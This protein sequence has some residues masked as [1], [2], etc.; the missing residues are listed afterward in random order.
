MALSLGENKWNVFKDKLD[1]VSNTDYIYT[2]HTHL[3]K[4][5]INYSEMER[6]REGGR[7][8]CVCVR[9]CVGKR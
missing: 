1:F 8:V 5:K 4:D 6:R 7:R 2:H 3:F 9:A